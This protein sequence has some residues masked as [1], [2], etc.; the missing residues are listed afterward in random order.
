MT[1]AT[2][3]LWT[4]TWGRPT[5]D[6]A[7]LAAAVQ[8]EVCRATLDYRTR[9]LIRDSLQALGSAWEFQRFD[10]WLQGSR[11]C[12]RLRAILN[13]ELGPPGYDF[14]GN[15]LMDAITPEIVEQYL[16]ELGGHLR[17]PARIVIGGAIALILERKLSRA[18]SDIDVV[19]ELPPELRSEHDL[20]DR[21][22]T[23]YRLRLTHFQ[24]HYLPSGWRGRSR[25]MGRFGELDVLLVDVYDLFVGKLFSRREKD[26]DDLRVL[27]PQLDRQC[28]V[29]RLRNSTVA[30]R[31]DPR[32]VEAAECN[33]YVLT[34]Q[35]LPPAEPT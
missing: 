9:L 19:D 34:G 7:A 18:T 28:L 4:L 15:R 3:D 29:E 8:R 10:R 11:H 2:E 20:L 32:L 22:A 31:R 33:W 35:P 27:F 13:E 17:R 16:R 21:L 24:S 26:L 30:F 5:V 6:P 12:E 1:P 25:S 14:S 23:R